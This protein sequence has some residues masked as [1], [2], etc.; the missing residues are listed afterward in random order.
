MM[1]SD[2]VWLVIIMDLV[3]YACPRSFLYLPRFAA[4]RKISKASLRHQ[5]SN[6]KAGIGYFAQNGTIRDSNLTR[7]VNTKPVKKLPVICP[8]P[9]C[10][11]RGQR[12]LQFRK[13]RHNPM[14]PSYVPLPR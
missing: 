9:L 8:S 12:R 14:N 5:K 10:G 4:K 1:L 11:L 7:E 13:C 2:Q 3:G 6:A